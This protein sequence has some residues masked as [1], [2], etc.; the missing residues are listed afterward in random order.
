MNAGAIAIA[1]AALAAGC[2]SAPE[3]D[4]FTRLFNGRDLSGWYGSEMYAVENVG[5]ENVL[6]FRPAKRS[7]V[8][9]G[10]LL[11][12]KEYSDFVLRFEFM[13][14]ENGDS[15]LGIR[16]PS[17]DV[18]AAYHGM[19]EIQLLDDG[20]S[21][22]YDAAAGKDR[23]NP[24]Q[25]ACSVFGV[26]PSRRDNPA[27]G[28]SGGGSYVRRPGEWNACEVKVAGEEIEVRLNGQLVTKGDLS[29][30][31]DDGGTLDRRRHPGLH[32]RRGHVGW[33]SDKHRVMWRN[34][35]IKEL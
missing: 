5:G 33:L 22:Y 13:L 7:A 27:A 19:C 35:F 16:T 3:G 29:G 30:I 23:I 18:D 31:S 34:I 20:G 32:R 15:G 1:A 21:E 6:V 9:R 8:D 24:Y 12:V 4:G 10:N 25:Y 26:V 11:T 14:P 2:C 17:P 28:F